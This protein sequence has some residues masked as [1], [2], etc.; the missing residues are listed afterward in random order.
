MQHTEM[1]LIIREATHTQI[2][3]Q[4]SVTQLYSLTIQG[5]AH[6]PGIST[7]ICQ[8]LHC[9]ARFYKQ[10]DLCISFSKSILNGSIL[11]LMILVPGNQVTYQLKHYEDMYQFQQDMFQ[12]QQD[13]FRYWKDMF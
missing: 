12:A 4:M 11:K 6:C 7:V 1:M 2:T 9:R 5:P 10:A 8:L 3:E 13:T